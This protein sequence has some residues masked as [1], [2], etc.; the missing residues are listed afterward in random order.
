MLRAIKRL[1]G[2]HPPSKDEAKKRLKL[3]LIHDQLNLTPTQMD[4]MKSEIM[5]VIRRYLVVDEDGTEFQ[6][7]RDDE[8]VKLISRVPV[9]RVLK[10]SPP[11]A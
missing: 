9:N 3:L 1:F 7:D 10:R 8:A 6:L 11:A 5:G 2:Y 4:D